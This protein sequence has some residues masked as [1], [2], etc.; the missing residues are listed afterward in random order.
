MALQER[1][2]IQKVC[3]QICGVSGRVSPREIER[4]AAND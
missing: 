2:S 1:H 4:V 3:G